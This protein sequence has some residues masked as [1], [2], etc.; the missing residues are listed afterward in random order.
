MSVSQP[1]IFCSF[2]SMFV[3]KRNGNPEKVSFDKIIQRIEGVCKQLDLNRIDPIEVAQETVRGLYNGMTTEELDVF[4]SIKCAERILDDPQY[5]SLAAGLSVSN[6][7]KSTSNNIMEVTDALYNNT[8]R[9]NK[10]NPRITNEYYNYVKQNVDKIQEKIDYNR[11]YLIDFFGIKTLE[12]SYLIRVRCV[13]DSN[14]KVPESEAKLR[15]SKGKIV[16][17][18]QHMFMR[19]ALAIHMDSL[20]EAFNT[21]DMM[22]KKYFTHASPTLYNAGCPKGQLASCFMEDTELL[23]VNEGVKKIQDVKINDTVVT[24]TGKIQK[25]VQFHK[26]L[27]GDRLIYRLKVASTKELFVTGN[28]RFMTNNGWISVDNLKVGDFIQI[29]KCEETYSTPKSTTLDYKIQLYHISRMYSVAMSN[30]TFEVNTDVNDVLTVNGLNYLRVEQL[31]QTDRRPEYVYTLGV[32]EDHSYNVEGLVCENCFLKGMDDDLDAIADTIHECM[33]I[34]KWAGGI[35]LHMSDIRARGSLIRGTNGES[36]GII[37]LIKTLNQIGRYVNQGGRRNGAIACFCKDSLVNT[38]NDGVKKIQDVKIGDIVR[39]H[40]NRLRPVVQ[41]HKNPLGHRQ[42]YKLQVDGHSDIYVT[43]NHR[44]W[45]TWKQNV[46]TLGWHSVKQL[47]DS[48]IIGNICYVADSKLNLKQVLNIVETDRT[49]EYVYTLG[50]EEDHSY[51]VED[52]VVENC[53]I[54]PWHADIY[55]FCELRK[56]TG[57]EELRARDIFLAL[58]VPDLFFKRYEEDGFWSLMCPDECPNLTNTYGEQFEKLYIGY[59][60][61]GRFK[62]KVRARDLFFHIIGCQI[63]TGMPYLCCKDTV[64]RCSNQKNIGTIKSSN[65]CA[66][67]NEYSDQNETAVCNLASIC[68]PMFVNKETKTYD[69]NTLLKVAETVCYN[70]NKIIDHTYYPTENAKISNLMHKPI[71]I[72]VQGLADVYCMLEIPF[73]SAEAYDLNKR[74]HETIYFGACTASN[75]LAKKYGPYSTFKGSPFSEGK[76]QF[77]L[78]GVSEDDLLMGYNWKSLIESVKQYGMRNSLLT[79]FMPTAS[80]SQIM[81]NNECFEPYT[82]NMYTRST[83]A[84][85]FIVVNNHLIETLIKNGLWTKN[86]KNEFLFDKGSVQNI[87]EIPQHIKD[88][89][90]TAFEMKIKPVVDQAIGRGLFC[91]QAQS[92]NLFCAEPSPQRLLS[93]HIY[94]WKNNLK[95]LLYYLRS[96]P[97]VDAIKFG[98][99]PKVA[100]KIAEK[101]GISLN[102]INNVKVDNNYQPCEMCSA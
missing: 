16:E 41:I 79:A 23:T 36:E 77:H 26:N 98:L 56:N 91:D 90:K 50:V 29:P 64:N 102:D 74:I 62:R 6:L 1:S 75:E 55:D 46:S 94:G 37:P 5:N 100:K 81:G 45:S 60:K 38:V 34:S 31:E 8:D 18:P 19:V 9:F 73:E 51:T 2:N 92:M 11:D 40:K 14:K 65:L 69:F 97:A 43:G 39:T 52:L 78:Q 10:H 88:V 59:E 72:G 66:E 63:E 15:S 28:H 89:Y 87:R 32:E 86:V 25:V 93:S 99:D 54:E 3:I 49:D 48:M 33:R 82:S 22:S 61:E 96:Q 7:H 67:I 44:F 70:L 85:E 4:A 35:G 83:Q 30:E 12:K 76:F 68:L 84:G 24:H 42:I 58:W 21:Y 101:R 53:Y 71:G 20:E 47:K 27:L 80:T 13:D 17:R 57:A 95:T